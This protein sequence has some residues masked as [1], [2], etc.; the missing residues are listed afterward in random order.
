VA[1]PRGWGWHALD[2][3]W[4]E[5]LVAEA[6]ITPGTLV[7]DVG[8]GTG[9]L[10]GPLLD[11]GARVIAVEA[12]PGRTAGLRRRFG[13]RIVVVQ[14]DAADLRLPRHRYRVVANPPFAVTSP[15]LRRLLQPGS[16][17]AGA[18]LVL[19]DQAARRWAGPGAPG[20]GRWSLVFAASLG[21]PLPRSAF[22]PPPRVKAT[23]LRIRTRL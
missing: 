19:Q 13:S 3:R 6:G 1:E 5:L 2:R 20:Y 9:G 14:A 12:H 21:R 8:A 15:L 4:A 23:V 11:A 22:H 18:D 16:R 17:L 7:V 10:T